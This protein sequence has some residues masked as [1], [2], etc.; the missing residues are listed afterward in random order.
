[1]CVLTIAP[2]GWLMGFGFPTGMRLIS[3]V[4]RTPT[5][6]FWGINGAAGVL[7]SILAVACSIAFGISTTLIIGALCYLALSPAALTIGFRA[8]SGAAAAQELFPFR[9]QGPARGRHRA[10][11]PAS[12]G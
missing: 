6:W 4:D 7:A 8:E 9:A 3:A 5:P 1:V 2:A 11:G 10:T 12:G